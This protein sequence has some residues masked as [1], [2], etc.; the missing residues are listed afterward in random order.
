MTT[1]EKRLTKLGLKGL[2][3]HLTVIYYQID[4]LQGSGLPAYERALTDAH[5][6]VRYAFPGLTIVLAEV[7]D[8]DYAPAMTHVLAPEPGT[9]KHQLGWHDQ[10][11]GRL[12]LDDGQTTLSEIES[13]EVSES[14]GGWLA[15][16]VAA[17]GA[18]S[19]SYILTTSTG[20]QRILVHGDI[21]RNITFRT[22]E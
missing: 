11:M 14:N 20:K 2:L 21:V 9:I 17:G 4:D 22:R 15:G 8:R 12:S 5:Q 1:F 10:A 19:Q 6:Q 18:A 13:C 3:E 7:H 16:T